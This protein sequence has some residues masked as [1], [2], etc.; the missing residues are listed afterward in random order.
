MR[1]WLPILAAISLAAPGTIAAQPRDHRDDK[2][3]RRMPPP[4]DDG[5]REAPPPPKAEASGTKAGYIWVT[6]RWTW[7]GGKYEWLPG[8]WERARAKKTWREGKWEKRGDRWAYVD[9]A[10]V[11]ANAPTPPTTP[12]TPP[13]VANDGPREAP[14]P[15]RDEK[16]D[17]RAGYVWVA[18]EWDWKNGKYEWIAGHWERERANKEW[19]PGRWEQREGRWQRTPGNWFD[20]SGPPPVAPPVANDGPREAPPA[21]RDERHEPSRAGYVWVAGEWDWKNG[22]YEWVPGHWERERANKQWRA[23]RWEQRDGRWMR[24]PGDWIDRDG[25]DDDRPRE[26]PPPMR[27]EKREPSRAG[28][29]WVAGEWDWK[30]GK[31]EW[32]AG[33]WER[34]RANKEWRPG[35]WEQRD[36]RWVRTPGDWFDRGAIDHRRRSWKFERPVVSNYWPAKGKPGA[37][38]VIR[39]KNFPKDAVV[40]WGGKE[41]RGVKVEDDQ[42]RFV[43]PNDATSGLIS[44]RVGRGRDLAVGTFEVAASFDAEAERRRMEEEAR[45]KAE[46][47]WAERRKQL[48]KDRAAREAAVRQRWEERAANRQQ[49]RAERL[50]QIRA[51]Y[52][53][54]FLADEETQAEMNLHAQRIAELERMADVAEIKADTKLGVRIDVLRQRE[55]QRHED[56]MAALDAAFRA[57]GAR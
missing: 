27:D 42:L 6:G 53:A 50:A 15:P 56:R 46:A 24:T 36:G 5:P 48:A 39:G 38:V 14:P 47:E 51:R 11:D 34:E 49:R 52:A 32:I 1:R 33:H 12:T 22:K 25:R 45:K 13:P 2:K 40:V 55:D 29:V 20:R 28:Y 54:A 44:V 26:A 16:H 35:R 7:K 9:G 19:R 41:I 31:Y 30:N 8:H 43:V 37:R 21:P 4:T 23:S 3:E 17:A 10:W 57:G 18:G